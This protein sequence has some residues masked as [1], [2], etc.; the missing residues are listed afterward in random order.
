[1]GEADPARE[2]IGPHGT[3]LTLAFAPVG[4]RFHMLYCEMP[5]S[6]SG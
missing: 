5:A 1:M 3:G 4:R 2:A 6:F